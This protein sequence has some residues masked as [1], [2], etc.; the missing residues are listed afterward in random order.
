MAIVDP[1]ITGTTALALAANILSTLV[2]KGILPVQEAL[3]IVRK[4]GLEIAPADPEQRK[5]AQH[6]LKSVLP[7]VSFD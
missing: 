7:D 5:A 4:V 2:S 6:A 3:D 1:Q